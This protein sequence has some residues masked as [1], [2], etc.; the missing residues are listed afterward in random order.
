MNVDEII[1]KFVENINSD[2]INFQR[3]AKADWIDEFESK[4]PKRLP[5]SFYYLISHYSFNSFDYNGLSFFANNNSDENLSVIVF[6]DRF[7]S[8][9]T[10]QNGY[11]QIARPDDGSYDPI[12]FDTN[13]S[14]SLREFP[15]VRIDHEGIL[16]RNKIYIL[17]TVSDSFLKFI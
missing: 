15:K 17:E 1:D 8:E 13:I 16:C 4:L 7:I 11:I 5:Q 3:T 9:L 6:K 10:L 12:C 2:E 14:R